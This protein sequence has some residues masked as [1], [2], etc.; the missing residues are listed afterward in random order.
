[1]R[2]VAA[3]WI[4]DDEGVVV[5]GRRPRSL[6]HEFWIDSEKLEQMRRDFAT[7]QKAPRSKR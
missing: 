2:W 3:A 5:A 6:M 4:E 7:P 1:M